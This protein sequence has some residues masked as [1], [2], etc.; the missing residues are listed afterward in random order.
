MNIVKC[1]D[2]INLFGYN[3]FCDHLKSIDW[4]RKTIIS[5]L[6]ASAIEWSKNDKAY[7]NSLLNADILIPDGISIKIAARI[8]LNVKIR[9]ISGEDLF[10]FLLKELNE[11]S[12]TCFFLG[13]SDKI[14]ESIKARLSKDYP[15]IKCGFFSPPFRSSFRDSDKSEMI[16]K[17]NEFT[18]DILF[19]GISAPKQ[20]K[21]INEIKDSLNVKII[22][23]IGAVFEMYAGTFKR[24]SKFWQALGLE[25]LI[26]WFIDPKRLKKKEYL[27]I[28][29]FIFTIISEKIN[30]LIHKN[31]RPFN[32]I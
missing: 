30:Q 13:S 25:W 8:L 4:G 5:T 23:N 18:P 27:N 16:I 21:L 1:V 24:P 10:L 6:N 17:V 22:C 14:L 11:K 31:R 32:F 15:K 3:V 2:K 26:T 28:I 7:K 9:K 29:K 19:V 12:K 20:E